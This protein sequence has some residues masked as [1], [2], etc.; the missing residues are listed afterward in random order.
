MKKTIALLAAFL[1][2]FALGCGRKPDPAKEHLTEEL[3]PEPTA[4]PTTAP[5]PEPTAE[6]QPTEVPE[7]YDLWKAVEIQTYTELSGE[8]RITII[9][10]VPAGA[11]LKIELP[12]QED[13]SYTN[14]NDHLITR[15][16]HI[17]V[18]VFFPGTPLETAEGEIA[19][20]VTMT[21]AD[22]EEHEIACPVLP[23]TFPTLS[24]DI[25]SAFE[26]A[27][28]GSIHVKA[29]ENGAY[30]LSG[31]LNDP[32]AIVFVD[33]EE[34]VGIAGGEI[35]VELAAADGA[36]ATH[37]LTVQKNNCVTALYTIVVEP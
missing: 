29:G 19:P 26:T 14:T 2:L 34:F 21:T 15:K 13:Y 28:D 35:T 31:M 18:E 32:T 5:T 33:G 24:L 12:G 17:P 23:Y 22:G 36:P 3:S 25:L 4:V 11:T 30:R 1:M 7:D 6:P 8:E 27:E 16:V 20:H 9:S 37:V 10:A